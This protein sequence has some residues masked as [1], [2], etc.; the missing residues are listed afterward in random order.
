MAEKVVEVENLTVVYKNGTVAVKDVSLSVERGGI[1]LFVGPDGA[2]KS[3]LFKSVAGVIKYSS[4]KVSVLG[5]DP[6]D[7]RDV[8]KIREKISFMP[9][10]LGLNLYQRLS[11]E[12]NLD[13]FAD[14]RGIEGKEKEEKKELF[15]KITGLYPFRDRKVEHLSGGMKQ[16]LG[17][18]CSLM[19]NP[20]IVILDEPTTGVDPVSRREIWN[21][22]YEFSEKEKITF[23]VS[24]SYIDEAER[25]T[26]VFVME[27]G[28][29]VLRFK[30][31][32]VSLE[33]YFNKKIEKSRVYISVPF[34]NVTSVPEKAVIVKN[35]TKK[36]GNFVAV[37]NVSLT[38]KRGEIAGFL[39]PN[40][41][42]KTTLMKTVLG[43]YE[44]DSGY[45]EV[46]GFKDVRKCRKIIGY[47]SQKFSLYEDMTVYE[48]LI[49]WGSVYDVPFWDLKK[50]IDQFLEI[51]RLRKFKNSFV[52]S[53]PL[54]VKQ[55]VSLAAALIHYPVILFLDEPTSGVDP[56]ERNVFWQIIRELSKKGV[57]S[58]VTTHYMDEAEFCDRVFL[59]REGRIFKEGSPDKLKEEVK[60]RAGGI[61]EIYTEFPFKLYSLLKGKGF[62]ATVFGRKVRIYADRSTVDRLKK[63]LGVDRVEEANPTMEDVFVFSVML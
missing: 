51:L 5:F 56:V 21:L 32:E 43:I 14:L 17:I 60:E 23:L 3:S 36:F 24:T 50:R 25:G 7:D 35:V 45:V 48:N 52:S 58:L 22:I 26:F 27:N 15:L 13:F 6:K 63:E 57:T 33:D 18:C 34:E 28:E 44:K 40:G 16:K 39:G 46:A 9:Q 59:M 62:K 42:G 37:N 11:V 55:R 61:Y 8:E 31:G 10:G 49:L 4:G 54:G 20:E 29:V 30:P 38:I 53:V 12:E 1:Y 2:G 47:T 41:A 19:H